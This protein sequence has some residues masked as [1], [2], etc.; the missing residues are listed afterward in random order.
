M[1]S[2]YSEVVSA[3]SD[4]ELLP[5]SSVLSIPVLFVPLALA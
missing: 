1:D 2:R 4:P 5:R 3:P